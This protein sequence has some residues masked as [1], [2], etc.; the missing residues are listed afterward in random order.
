MGFYNIINKTSQIFF[1][2]FYS[3]G[4]VGPEVTS[5]GKPILDI[6]SH[7]FLDT[8]YGCDNF[9]H[10]NYGI[11]CYVYSLSKKLGEMRKDNMSKE[12][13]KELV[14]TLTTKDG[15]TAVKIAMQLN[16]DRNPTIDGLINLVALLDKNL[17]LLA[18]KVLEL[19][20]KL[21]NKNATSV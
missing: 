13:V 5:K 2:F 17:K 4:W 9:D 3:F 7:N 8:R 18:T 10:F 11:L 20:K 6:V 16:E 15:V 21:E 12:T 1:Y 14:D 19:E